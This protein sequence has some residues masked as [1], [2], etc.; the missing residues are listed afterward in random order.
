MRGDHETALVY[1]KRAI[2][3]LEPDAESNQDSFS[4]SYLLGRLYFRLG[5][6]EAVGRQDHQAAV[7]WFE[8]A[9]PIFEDSVPNLPQPEFGRL[10]ETFVSMGVSFWESAQRDR[11]IRLTE[12]G[13]GLIEQAVKAGTLDRSA[14]EIP[15]NN[16]A[17]MARHMGKDE[18]ADKYLEEAKRY[19]KSA[20]R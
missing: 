20:T 1:G 17:T 7:S 11:A 9:I 15:Y 6:I 16:L 5:A 13:V 19:K 3:Y 2:G 12:R 18:Q 14:L 8:K 10:G 4:E